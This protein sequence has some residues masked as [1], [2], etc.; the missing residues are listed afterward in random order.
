[1]ESA[2]RPDPRCQCKQI[3]WALITEN[4]GNT[5]SPYLPVLKS[6]QPRW[7]GRAGLPP[8]ALW[9]QPGL[10]GPRVK[11]GLSLGLAGTQD[12]RVTPLQ[13]DPTAG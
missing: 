8:A 12:C 9:E 2:L 3:L 6:S 13:G 7:A 11:P 1:M 5:A 10:T 4:Q